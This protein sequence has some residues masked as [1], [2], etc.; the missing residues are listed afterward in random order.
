MSQ[1]VG[2]GCMEKAPLPHFFPLSSS[3]TAASSSDNPNNLPKSE[4]Q[5]LP[6]DNPFTA[7]HPVIA[8]FS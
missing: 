2:G 3:E 4:L 1:H 6:A 5:W 8:I 7:I